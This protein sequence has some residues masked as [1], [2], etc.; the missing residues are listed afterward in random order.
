MN[1]QPEIVLAARQLRKTF[2]IGFL[3]KRVDAVTDASFEVYRGEIFGLVGHNG[4]GKTTTMKI[5]MGLIAPDGGHGEI[6]GVPVNRP[7]ARNKVGF[8]PETPHFYEYLRPAELLDFFAELYGLDRVTKKKRIPE[9][10]ELVGLRGAEE[11]QLRKFSKG[12]LQRLGLAQALLPD[13]EI[14]LLDE[15]QSGLDPLGRKDVRDIIT[16]QRDQ[17]KTVIFSSHVLPDVEHICD[18]IAIMT[19][20]KVVKQG[21]IE[22]LLDHTER[23]VEVIAEPATRGGTPLVPEGFPAPS[24]L[25]D[26]QRRFVVDGRE[27]ADRLMGA[28]LQAGWSIVSVSRHRDRLEDLF[29]RE[30]IGQPVPNQGA[31]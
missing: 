26:G 12:M 7:A 9:L 21:R 15:P 13:S 3:R 19:R 14:I 24:P 4:A 10:L 18:R 5:L 23:D 17:G 28:L 11:K 30:T 8:L 25:P 16:S 22:D 29:V 6:L 27:T 1:S 20:G 31:A 2:R